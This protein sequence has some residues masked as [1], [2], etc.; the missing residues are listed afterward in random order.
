MSSYQT[1]RSAQTYYPDQTPAPTYAPSYQQSYG[2]Y[3]VVTEQQPV[4]ERHTAVHRAVDA[5]ATNHVLHFILTILTFGLWLPVWIAYCVVEH[6]NHRYHSQYG[7]ATYYETRTHRGRHH[8]H[9]I[10]DET[11]TTTTTT[12]DNDVPMVTDR[13]YA[14]HYN[15]AASSYDYC[16][17]DNF[18]NEPYAPGR[19]VN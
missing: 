16:E 11:T 10:N 13:D 8:R 5:N 14:Y 15:P 3:Y 1:S 12:Y 18:A 19:S 7:S 2:D 4:V 17:Y 6:H 9:H